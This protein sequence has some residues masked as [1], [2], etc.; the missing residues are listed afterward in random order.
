MQ[1]ERLIGLLQA[2]RIANVGT[3]YRQSAASLCLGE[4]RQGERRG[5]ARSDRDDNVGGADFVLLGKPGSLI[6]RVLGAFHRLQQGVPA[7][8][9][10]KEQPLLRPAEG[11]N[12]L[13]PVLDGQPARGPGADVDQPTAVS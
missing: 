4:A 2:R 13:R 9:Y 10:E 3:S 8:G 7:A 6:D 5:T 12:E 1:P 11:R